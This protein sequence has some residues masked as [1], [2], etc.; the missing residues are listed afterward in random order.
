MTTPEVLFVTVAQA[1][2]MTSLSEW[3]VRHR[4]PLRREGRRVLVPLSWCHA[5]AHHSEGEEDA[6]HRERLQTPEDP[7]ERPVV[8]RYSTG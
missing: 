3:A 8:A 4:A 1:A 5:G 2:A 6:R 7:P